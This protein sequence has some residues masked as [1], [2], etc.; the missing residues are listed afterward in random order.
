MASG[1]RESPVTTTHQSEF[2][3]FIRTLFYIQRI[4][5]AMTVPSAGPRPDPILVL[6][7]GL[8]SKASRKYVPPLNPQVMAATKN[9]C[10]I[11]RKK[12][13]IENAGLQNIDNSVCQRFPALA[14]LKVSEEEPGV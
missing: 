11:E 6:N 7:H 3:A 4:P 12:F 1:A 14:R 10:E 2:S 8:R 13:L 9:F 5:I